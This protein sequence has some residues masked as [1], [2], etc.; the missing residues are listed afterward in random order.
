MRDS[1]K[2][3]GRP[4]TLVGEK[5]FLQSRSCHGIFAE[6]KIEPGKRAKASWLETGLGKGQ[7]EGFVSLEFV[8]VAEKS[9][10][11]FVIDVLIGLPEGSSQKACSW[12]RSAWEKSPSPSWVVAMSIY[13]EGLFGS[14][15]AN[16]LYCSMAS[17]EIKCPCGS[18]LAP[19][20]LELRLA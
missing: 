19:T 14:I 20:W 16:S 9:H 7:F 4:Y 18:A 11:V 10:T 2:Q 5:C 1:E 8:T 15:L 12:L 3:A 13:V 6:V 17:W